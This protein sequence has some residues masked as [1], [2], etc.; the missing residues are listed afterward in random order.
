VRRILTGVDDEAVT[1][2]VIE[3]IDKRCSIFEPTEIAVEGDLRGRVVVPERSFLAHSTLSPQ[4]CPKSFLGGCFQV[5]LP[6]TG[7]S[8]LSQPRQV[9]R[10][11]NCDCLTAS[12]SEICNA[13][14]RRASFR[15]LLG[16]FERSMDKCF[17]ALHG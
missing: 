5:P 17:G 8:S 15:G 14:A 16:R 3:I 11:P 1:G 10:K 4:R 9:D 13:R 7:P 2:R 6:E 12:G